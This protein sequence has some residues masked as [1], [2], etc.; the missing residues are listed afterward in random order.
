[1]IAIER[2]SV[3]AIETTDQPRAMAPVTKSCTRDD[4]LRIEMMTEV[5]IKTQ[6][7]L[8]KVRKIALGLHLASYVKNTFRTTKLW[9]NFIPCKINAG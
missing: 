6:I 1:M 8:V 7:S 5:V 4:L 2:N 9:N 3:T